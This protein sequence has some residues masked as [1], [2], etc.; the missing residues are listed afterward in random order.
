MASL[1]QLR[2][3]RNKLRDRISQSMSDTGSFRA[4]RNCKSAQRELAEVNKRIKAKKNRAK[5]RGWY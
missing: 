3:Q 1:S 5:K 4:T 2:R